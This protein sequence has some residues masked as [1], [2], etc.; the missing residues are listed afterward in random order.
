MLDQHRRVDTAALKRSHPIAEVVSGYG[1]ELHPAGRAL[2][3]RCPLHTDSGRPNLHVYADTDSWYCYRCGVGGDAIRFV[4]CVE[5]TDFLAAVAR[6]G[7]AIQ[8]PE[9]AAPPPQ[10]DAAQA[11]PPPGTRDRRPPPATSPAARACL[12]AAVELYANRLLTDGA[13]LAYVEG[14]GLDRATIEH[15]RLGFAA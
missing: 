2:V 15:C 6:L 3:G 12:A 1:V 11:P 8:R 7:G 14:R 13:A 9:G 5:R 4:E 10:R